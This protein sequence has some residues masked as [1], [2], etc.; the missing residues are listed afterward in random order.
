MSLLEAFGAKGRIFLWFLRVNVVSN[1]SVLSRDTITPDTKRTVSATYW[2]PVQSD[3]D[4]AAAPPVLIIC[5]CTQRRGVVVH[6]FAI[7]CFSRSQPH[8]V[9][10]C[11]LQVLFCHFR[12][13]FVV[14]C[15]VKNICSLCQRN[16]QALSAATGWKAW[17]RLASTSAA[18]KLAVC[19]AGWGAHKLE[20]TGRH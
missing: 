1:P 2:Q 13:F 19:A 4:N 5:A 12:R 14:P 18:W 17:S 7:S 10:T 16:E 20:G 8:F 9:V 3:I 11:P 15:F 6:F